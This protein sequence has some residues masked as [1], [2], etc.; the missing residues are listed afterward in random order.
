MLSYR[1][2]NIPWECSVSCVAIG[3]MKF[4]LFDIWIKIPVI[5]QTK[6]GILNIINQ[7]NQSFLCGHSCSFPASTHYI[8]SLQRDTEHRLS[9]AGFAL[10][11]AYRDGMGFSEGRL[12]LGN[13]KM[14]VEWQAD[15]RFS[16]YCSHMY[17]AMHRLK[18]EKPNLIKL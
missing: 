18:E 6:H 1:K 8:H 7:V 13:K 15:P 12:P 11:T 16:Q 2:W 3:G 9:D 17:V 5:F 10:V 14:F 4:V